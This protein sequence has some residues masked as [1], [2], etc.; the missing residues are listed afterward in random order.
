[1]SPPGPDTVKGRGE[2]GGGEGMIET[3]I[4]TKSFSKASERPEPQGKESEPH[5]GLGCHQAQKVS[6]ACDPD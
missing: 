3:M 2:T 4:E 1:M 6:V 5:V